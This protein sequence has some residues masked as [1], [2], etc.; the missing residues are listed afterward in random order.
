MVLKTTVI[1]IIILSGI[2]LNS[3]IPKIYKNSLD[4]L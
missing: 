2:F 4:K 1:I 3:L